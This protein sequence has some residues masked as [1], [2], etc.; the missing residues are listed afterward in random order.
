M[1][2]GG[3]VVPNLPP[4]IPRLPNPPYPPSLARQI[5]RALAGFLL[6]SPLHPTYSR[7]LPSFVHALAFF[8]LRSSFF[9]LLHLAHLPHFPPLTRR[10][11]RARRVD[12]GAA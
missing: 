2:R 10:S 6:Y 7:S 1:R 8:S 9:C 5:W 11:P 12:D 3:P 4:H